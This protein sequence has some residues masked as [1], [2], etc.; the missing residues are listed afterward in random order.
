MDVWEHFSVLKNEGGWLFRRRNLAERLDAL[1]KILETGDWKLICFLFPF[2]KDGNSEIRIA[3]ADSISH[4]FHRK[5]SKNNYY[6]S[7]KYCDISKSDIDRFRSTFDKDQY[8]VLLQ[9]ASLNLNGYIREQAVF[10]LGLSMDEKAIPFIIHRLGDWVVQVRIAAQAAI[11]S[12][13]TPKHLDGF[14]DNLPEIEGLQRIERVNLTPVYQSLM[15][16][17]VTENRSIV[18]DNF[19]SHTEKIRG[20]LGRHLSNSEM[21]EQDLQLFRNDPSPHIRILAVDHF[22]SLSPGDIARLLND[23]SSRIRLHTLYKLK[24]TGDFL[25]VI[26][27]YLADNAASIR[28]F[29]RFVLKDEKVNFAAY[30]A[31]NLTHG[32]AIEPSLSGLA[33]VDGKEFASTV[34]PYLDSSKIKIKKAALL[35]LTRLNKPKAYELAMANLD[36][37][38][39]GLRKLS[40]R[41]LERMP[42][43]DVLERIRGIVKC[44]SAELRTEMLGMLSRIGRWAA[45]SDILL[46]TIDDKDENIRQEAVDYLHSWIFRSANLFTRPSSAEMEN[47]RNVLRIVSEEHQKMNYFE[48]NPV[49]GFDFYLR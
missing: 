8:L 32:R 16:F 29:A 23:K 9:I 48:N 45:I 3:T 13:K 25:D 35:A 6:E 31:D 20:I 11:E 2:L 22:D 14:I 15:Y 36:N 10:E 27:P 43:P 33:E 19:S 39:K 24:T 37:D 49:D 42:T 21:T 1:N 17:I 41:F 38:L 18:R 30:Y 44:G 40:T 28:Q 47:I 46:A 4:L 26:Q 7:L 34:E 12:F 5:V